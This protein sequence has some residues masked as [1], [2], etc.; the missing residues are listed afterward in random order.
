[1]AAAFREFADSV[2]RTRRQRAEEQGNKASVKLL[3][4]VVLCLAPPIYI[5][6]LGPATLELKNFMNRENMPGGVLAT[7]TS[8]DDQLRQA[9]GP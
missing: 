7:S 6:L 1:V 2:R 9:T 5:L 8:I 3:F 4:P